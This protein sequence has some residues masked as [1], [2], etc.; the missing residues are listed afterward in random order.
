[1][2]LGLPLHIQ[3]GYG[4]AQGG[5]GHIQGLLYP[6]PALPSFYLTQCLPYPVPALPSAC[7]THPYLPPVLCRWMVCLTTARVRLSETS[8]REPLMTW[9]MLALKASTSASISLP[10]TTTQYSR[11]LHHSGC[12][13]LVVGGA[14][15]LVGGVPI[16][17]LLV[18]VASI[19]V[20]GASIIVGG[21]S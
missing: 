17:C 3:G 6:V 21:V 7:L 20:G 18:G 4:H 9:Q 8:T 2:S 10:Y 5:C 11:C 1:M 12:G 19:L 14:S 13:L 16:I 15:I